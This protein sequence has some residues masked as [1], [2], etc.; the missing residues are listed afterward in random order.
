MGDTPQWVSIKQFYPRGDLDLLVDN[1][2]FF[3]EI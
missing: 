1:L 3:R 2:S